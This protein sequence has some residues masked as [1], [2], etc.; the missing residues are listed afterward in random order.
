M[1]FQLEER[2]NPDGKAQTYPT[3]PGIRPAHAK[4]NYTC[5]RR[6][7]PSKILLVQVGAL[8]FSHPSFWRAR[9]IYL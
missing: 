8:S 6:D 3:Y 5:L 4:I 2:E 1:K 9:F 7:L